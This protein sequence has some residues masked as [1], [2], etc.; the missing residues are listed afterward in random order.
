MDDDRIERD[1]IIRA[2]SER[3]WALA[4][5]AGVWVGVEGWGRQTARLQAVAET[6]AR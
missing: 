2:G 1:I 3:V 5:K 6:A 4:S